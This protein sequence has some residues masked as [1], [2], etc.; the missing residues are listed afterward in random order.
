[1]SYDIGQHVIATSDGV[2]FLSRVTVVTKTN[3]PYN[4]SCTD[5]RGLYRW[6]S[7]VSLSD[8]VFQWR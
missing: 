1:M 8:W 5:T 6:K 2:T 7:L 4:Y 3:F